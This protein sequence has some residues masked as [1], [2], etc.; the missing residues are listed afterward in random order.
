MKKPN[1]FARNRQAFV[2]FLYAKTERFHLHDLIMEFYELRNG[3]ILI[4]PIETIRSF[5]DDLHSWGILRQYPSKEY[6]VVCPNRP[7][8]S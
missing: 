6:Q 5:V 8:R 2:Q 4:D 3:D 1:R 7:T